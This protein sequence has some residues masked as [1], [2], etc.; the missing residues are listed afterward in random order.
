MIETLLG[1]VGI[2]GILVLVCMCADNIPAK[3]A[4]MLM[5]FFEK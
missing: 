4:D 5:R 1:I 3:V 2:G